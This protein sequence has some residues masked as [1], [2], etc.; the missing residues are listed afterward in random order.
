MNDQALARVDSPA[1]VAEVL[2]KYDTS[3]FIVLH[4]VIVSAEGTFSPLLVTSAAVVQVNPDPKGMDVYRGFW[5]GKGCVAPTKH[6]LERIATAGGV[7]WERPTFTGPVTDPNTGHKSVIVTAAAKV[8]QPDGGWVGISKSKELDTAVLEERFIADYQRRN[9]SASEQ[10]ARTAVRGLVLQA[11]ENL[12]QLAE[13][14]AMSRVIRAIFS[15]QQEYP[16]AQLARCPIVV[17]RIVYDP[18]VTDPAQLEQIQLRGRRAAAELYGELPDSTGVASGDSGRELPPGDST[19]TE[20]ETLAYGEG[21]SGSDAGPVDEA[22]GSA[23]DSSAGVDTQAADVEKASAGPVRPDE[24]D[25]FTAGDHAGETFSSVAEFFPEYAGDVLAG[26][27]PGS[28]TMARERHQLLFAWY[29][30]F[31]PQ[32][33]V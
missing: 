14:K 22:Q 16:E 10:D 20:E 2:A 24:D 29:Q 9:R 11:K 21:V 3:Q 12:V 1:P 18:D 30:F 8:R 5:T 17:P 26:T 31:N 33:G 13:S 28:K 19:D 23:G 7:E 25:T 6:L 15:L 4:P 32:P 27:A